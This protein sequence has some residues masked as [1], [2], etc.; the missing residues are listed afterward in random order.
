VAEWHE[1]LLKQ[2]VLEM[3]ARLSSRVFLGLPLCRNEEWLEIAKTYTVAAFMA[4][5]ELREVSPILRPILHWFK[6]RCR[7]ARRQVRKAHELIDPEVK[8]RQQRVR[9]AKAAG[10]KPP[11]TA[12]TIGWMYEIANG[13]PLDFTLAQ[14]GLTIA[15]IHTT[16]EVTTRAF[17]DIC[18]KPE[19]AEALRKEV[20]QVIRDNGWSKVSL[21]KLR[22]MDSFIKESQRVNPMGSREWISPGQAWIES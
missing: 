16:T 2:N 7:E 6:P 15:A 20:I 3:V 14:L 11:K 21:Y 13:K 22:L 18:S 9:E 1:T 12:D 8:K 5:S 4:A 19:T 10:M 17:I